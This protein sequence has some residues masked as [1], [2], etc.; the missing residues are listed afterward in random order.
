MGN[1]EEG[2]VT[3]I[4]VSRKSLSSLRNKA[5]YAS[6]FFHL[7]LAESK[8]PELLYEN[9][10]R[11]KNAIHLDANIVSKVNHDKWEKKIP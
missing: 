5:I 10:Q 9:S 2:L 7:V 6:V 1:T 11:V 8:T 4:P 3:E